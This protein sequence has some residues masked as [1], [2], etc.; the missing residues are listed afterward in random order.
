MRKKKTEDIQQGTDKFTNKLWTDIVNERISKNRK[1]SPPK[2]LTT[3]APAF[4]NSR[5]RITQNINN[6]AGTNKQT[7]VDPKPYHQTKGS[8]TSTTEKTSTHNLRDGIDKRIVN[9][10]SNTNILADQAPQKST[11]PS[12]INVGSSTSYPNMFGVSEQLPIHQVPISE[13]PISQVLQPQTPVL[14]SGNTYGPRYN[15][16]PNA[17]PMQQFIPSPTTMVYPHSQHSPHIMHLQPNLPIPNVGS[18]YNDHF[19]SHLGA[20]TRPA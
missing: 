12:R 15:T 13:I 8:H 19:L 4:Y 2:T 10:K 3:K 5:S 14:G 16:Q 17:Y 11:N 9:E 1:K 6:I 18:L 7:I 20:M